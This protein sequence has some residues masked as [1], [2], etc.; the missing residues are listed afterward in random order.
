MMSRLY[1]E[2]THE[3]QEYKSK[4]LVIFPLLKSVRLAR[5]YTIESN[6]IF[7]H[8]ITLFAMLSLLVI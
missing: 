4:S 6:F 8:G 2:L 7:A 1:W 5:I 3:K